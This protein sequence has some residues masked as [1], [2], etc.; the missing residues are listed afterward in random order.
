MVET[1]IPEADW[2]QPA[3]SNGSNA[4][5]SI[6]SLID[7][8]PP[9]TSAVSRV[10]GAAPI[11][12]LYSSGARSTE[13]DGLGNQIETFATTHGDPIWAAV[14]AIPP[15][16]TAVNRYLTNSGIMR[17][18]TRPEPFTTKADY[19]SWDTLTDRTYS[20]RHLPAARPRPGLPAL[21]EFEPLYRRDPFIESPKSTVLFSYFAQ[22][23]TDGFLRMDRTWP[24][25]DLRRN[26]SNHD[27]DL[28]NLYGLRPAVTDQLRAHEGG[29]LKS[30]LIKGEEFPPYLYAAGKQKA[31]F[32][33]VTVLGR[34]RWPSKAEN[35]FFAMGGDTTNMQIGFVMHNV[36]FLREHNRIARTLQ[37]TY[38]TWD[39][40]RLFETARSIMIVLLIKVV[41]EDYINHIT[42]Y[43]FKLRLEPRSFPNEP[44]YRQN[45]MATEFQLLYRWH[46][47]VPSSYHIGGR[48]YAIEATLFNTETV[49]K[50]GLG[51]MFED[52]SLQSAGQVGLKNTP[53]GLLWE[54]EKL[55]IQQ[56]R[57]GERELLDPDRAFGTADQ[58][59]QRQ[60]AVAGLHQHP[61]AIAQRVQR[62]Q[63]RMPIHVPA[64]SFHG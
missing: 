34:E 49:V 64:L 16:R 46:S 52:A 21:D 1:K 9:V 27:I 58:F 45:W 50:T 53:P 2:A 55:S 36:L 17:F 57:V 30:Q 37:D 32:S 26:E 47:L 24:D 28:T 42:P 3:E 22:W 19:T 7:A 4:T 23:F 44:W 51:A 14:Q 40:E 10:L 56:G 60:H 6:R 18:P 31:E 61:G 20:A 41:I 43:L 62:I 33:E 25:P 54:V 8:V 39:D 63:A 29:Q 12:G 5:A 48:E 13:K 11:P 15:L 35:K 38:P 59:Q